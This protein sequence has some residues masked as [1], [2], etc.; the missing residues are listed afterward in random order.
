MIAD[1]F[2]LIGLLF[3]VFIRSTGLGF[4]ILIVMPLIL[5]MTRHFQKASLASQKQNPGRHRQG[6]PPYSRNSP[7]SLH[8]PYL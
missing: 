2:Q 1:L 4:I 3:V 7:G 5:V 6:Q 8:D